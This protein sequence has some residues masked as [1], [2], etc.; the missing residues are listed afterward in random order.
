MSDCSV[1]GK[2]AQPGFSVT[3][4]QCKHT[5]HTECNKDNF[6]PRKCPVCLAGA[7]VSADATNSSVTT[8]IGGAVTEPRLF[9]GRDYVEQPGDPTGPSLIRKG[10]SAVASKIVGGSAKSAKNAPEITSTRDVLNMRLP[11]KTIWAKHGYGLDHMLRDGILIDD[12][13]RNR[14]KLSDLSQFQDISK[15]GPRRALRAFAHGLALSASHLKDHP[16]LLPFDQFK[17]LTQIEPHQIGDVLGLHFPEDGPLQ[18]DGDTNWTAEDC[19]RLGL[20]FDDLKELGLQWTEQYQDLMKGI[21]FSKMERVET[22]LGVTPEKLARLI[23]LEQLELQELRRAQKEAEE[24]ERRRQRAYEQSMVVDTANSV[25]DSQHGYYLEPEAPMYQPQ[26]EPQYESSEDDIIDDIGESTEPPFFDPTE[27]QYYAPSP[28]PEPA[29]KVVLA[30][31]RPA[32]TTSRVIMRKP[33]PAP[34]SQRELAR[35]RERER[36]KRLGLKN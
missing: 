15:E 9:D 29:P 3:H 25:A 36:L 33:A 27:E 2:R 11:I 12:F 7:A 31:R 22:Q 6:D 23:S 17:E 10:L 5:S 32:A 21:P 13:L 24:A 14:Y 28:E 1:C 19:V 8:T 20:S 16:D 35:Q 4:I 26:Y 34:R 30:S 18:C